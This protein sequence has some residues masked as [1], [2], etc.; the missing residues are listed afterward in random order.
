MTNAE[1]VRQYKSFFFFRYSVLKQLLVSALSTNLVGE[2]K[3]LSP[4][5]KQIASQCFTLRITLVRLGRSIL[6]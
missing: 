3:N 1:N 6:S 2:V 4:S 5:F